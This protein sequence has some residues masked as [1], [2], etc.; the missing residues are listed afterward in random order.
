VKNQNENS[1]GVATGAHNQRPARLR[2]VRSAR[3]P[4]APSVKGMWTESSFTCPSRT[5]VIG[6]LTGIQH[7]KRLVS[8]SS[9]RI[10]EG[11]TMKTIERIIHSISRFVFGLGVG[12][13]LTSAYVIVASGPDLLGAK[14]PAEVVRLDPVEVTISAERF[15]EIRAEA[16]PPTK[17]VHVFGKGPQ[18]V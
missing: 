8:R 4:I 14:A 10:K 1:R 9:N 6:S 12:L 13:A 15:K 3:L 11:I 16:E 2:L 18:Q 17:V 7:R 5:L